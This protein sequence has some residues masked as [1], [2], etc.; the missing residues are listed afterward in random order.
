MLDLGVPDT[1]DTTSFDTSFA[2]AGGDVNG[3]VDYYIP[4]SGSLLQVDPF[5]LP[6]GTAGSSDG[7]AYV[8]PTGDTLNT[9]QQAAPQMGTAG[10]P[11]GNTWAPL[12]GFGAPIVSGLSALAKSSGI[13]TPTK[14]TGASV[15]ALSAAN[16]LRTLFD[17]TNH[18]LTGKQ[19]VIGGVVL[20]ALIYGITK[21]KD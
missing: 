12:L 9:P 2:G 6:N 4:P 17:T 13:L 14:A 5:L 21:F 18:G 19:V 16:P 20:L 10:S 15:T 7:S 1:F 3:T 11:P 8:A